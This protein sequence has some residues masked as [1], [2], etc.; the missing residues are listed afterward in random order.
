LRS[1]VSLIQ[2][3]GRV[4]RNIH[5]TAILYADRITG[6]MERAIKET[7]RRRQKQKDYNASHGITPRSVQKA[8]KDIMEG[9][10]GTKSVRGK[11]YPKRSENKEDYSTLNPEALKT[12]IVELEKKMYNHAHNLE[13]EE[14][15]RLRDLIHELQKN[16]IAM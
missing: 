7:E 1:E 10:Y 6:S 12:K 3:I 9:A 11:L 5:G 13:F 8:V 16:V 14:A 15:A 2:T 4:A